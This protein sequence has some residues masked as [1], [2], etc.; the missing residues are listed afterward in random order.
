MTCKDS[1]MNA[2]EKLL[3][4]KQILLADGATGTNLFQIGL[5]SGYPPELWNDEHPEKIEWLHNGFLDAGADIILTNSFGGTKHRLKLHDAQ[6]RVHELNVK[7]A[8]IAR[9]CADQYDRD[10]IIA[11]SMGPTGELLEPVGALSFDEAVEAFTEQANALKEGGADIA[12]IETMSA[13]NEVR[14]AAKAAENAGLDYVFTMSFDTAG[15]SMMGVAPDA[16]VEF[17][18]SMDPKPHACG[19]NCGVGASDMVASALVMTDVEDAPIIV[20]KGNC[21]IPEFKEG[22][23][24]YTGTPEVMAEYARTAIDSGVRIIGGCCGTSFEH[25]KAMRDAIDSHEKRDK[26]NLEEI[27]QRLGHFTSQPSKT[28]SKE[29]DGKEAPARRRR[30]RG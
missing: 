22:E 25:L 15:K 29:S 13:E 19:A 2:L 17:A 21:G 18:K 16:M 3:N 10:I 23:L 27:E 30:R 14:A 6:D 11:G 26:P 4:E 7:A 5:E 20:A 28:Q 9:K 12:W 1:I 8:Q 24:M